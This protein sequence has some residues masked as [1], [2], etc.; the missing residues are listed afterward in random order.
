MTHDNISI[1]LYP[2]YMLQAPQLKECGKITKGYVTLTSTGYAL[3]NTTIWN[4]V[5]GMY[6]RS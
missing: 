1:L 5:S 6:W 2:T 3:I 4:L